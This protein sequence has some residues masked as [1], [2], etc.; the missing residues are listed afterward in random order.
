MASVCPELL[1]AG[2]GAPVV[3][4]N[5]PALVVAPAAADL[6]VA[7]RESLAA[8]AGP[9]RERDRGAVS[10]LDVCLDPM[11][12]EVDESVTQHQFEPVAHEP[13]AGVR[14]AHRIT[15]VCALERASGD[16]GQIEES[17]DRVVV[18]AAYE[19]RLEVRAPSV[20]E[21][22]QEALFVG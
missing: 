5:R 3:G 7:T 1:R 14:L 20:C 18:A 17:H 21:V 16:V 15:E 6:E 8:K 4:Q 13:L 19:H 2:T 10:G 9:S 12:I 11:E 22:G